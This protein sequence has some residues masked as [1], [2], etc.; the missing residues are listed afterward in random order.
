MPKRIA[1]A[2]VERGGEVLIG[3]RPEGVPLAG[4]W[5]FPGG[6]VCD[7]ETYEAAVIR[8]CQEETGLSVLVCGEF[9]PVTHEYRHATVALR[10]FR[11]KVAESELEETPRG[12]FRWVRKTRL[13]E[14]RFPEANACL[15]TELT[16]EP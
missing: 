4:Y 15:L 1:I 9:T 11:C 5:E 3:Q 13:S 16:I 7:G 14:Y 6:K 10:F 12:S 2:V 8:E